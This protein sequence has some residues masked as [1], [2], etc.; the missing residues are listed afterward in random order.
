MMDEDQDVNK[1]LTDEQREIVARALSGYGEQG[2]N[3]YDLNEQ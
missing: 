3:G 2:A 1:H